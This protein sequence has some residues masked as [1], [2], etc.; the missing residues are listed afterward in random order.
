[1]PAETKPTT[2][3]D[4]LFGRPIATEDEGQEHLGAL[5]G[6]GVLGLDAL[7]SA[8][9]GPEALLTALLP[10][11]S[12]ASRYVLPLTLAIVGL[13]LV[14]AL[15]YRQTIAA[16]PNGGG[17]YTVAK[18]N[19][20]QAPALVAAAALT[21][22][23]VLN[24][25]VAISAGVGALVSAVPRLLP[26]T[27]SLCLAVLCVLTL[28]NL[29]G[30]RTTGLVFLLPTYAFLLS[31]ATVLGLGLLGGRWVA[32]ST[33]HH[34]P[35]A[36]QAPIWLLL[37]A[38]ANGCSAMTG[39]EAVSNGVPLF[40]SPAAQVARRTLTAIV[41]ALGLLLYGT[42]TLAAKRGVLATEPG[43]PGYQSVISQL[44]SGVLGSGTLY[45]LVMGSV[46]SVLVFSANTS[47]ADFPR[48]CRVL[49]AD[50]YLPEPFV[51]RGR[52]LT[53]SH[54]I[55]LLALLSGSLLVVFGGITD[56]LIPLFAVGA[57]GA[58][59]F[60]QLGMMAHWRRQRLPG[61][62]RW[63]ALNGAG[64][65][66]TGLTLL[67]VIVSKLTE[68]AW[69]SLLLIGGI[70]WLLRNVHRHYD[71]IQR[72]T[73]VDASAELGP[74][75]P[76]LAIVPLRRWDGVALKALRIA[77]GSAEQVLAVQ[78]LTGDREIDDLSQRWAELVAGAA[79][80][81]GATPPRLVVLR[82]AYRDLYGPLLELVARLEQEHAGKPIMVVV[83]E[84][85]EARWYQHLL[86]NHTASLLKALL[87]YH[88]GPQTIIVSAP[89]YLRRPRRRF[90]AQG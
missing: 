53:F 60:S 6:I 88:G 90:R 16:Y 3:L 56:A 13:L 9:Y 46:I 39:V 75:R 67:V 86:H 54:G 34:L 41:L 43:A 17:A 4:L 71:T 7:A 31:M 18:E 68:G 23:Y 72:A 5:T 87:L 81:R 57:L 63:L 27:L 66:A 10:L 64:A 61:S 36:S 32:P 22:D 70:L 73:A 21:L 55:V 29:R 80:Q 77:L 15:S 28:L 59:T 65:L 44:A 82:S 2:L 14:T 12:G 8:S 76:K 89:F 51:H 74:A 45:Y 42:A 24:V 20:G 47:F 37:R 35:L 83:G 79:E 33:S 30:I 85:V 38:F 1:M 84:L 19:L 26:H 62:R 52:R 40:K 50:R 49:A 11:G 69:I 25:A 48:V 78:V 58:F